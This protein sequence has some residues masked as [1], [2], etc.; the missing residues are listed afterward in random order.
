MHVLDAIPL[1]IKLLICPKVHSEHTKC[2]FS[3]V[4]LLQRIRDLLEYSYN[5]DYNKLAVIYNGINFNRFNTIDSNSVS[6]ATLFVGEVFWQLDDSR[7]PEDVEDR[8]LVDGVEQTN[9]ANHARIV[10][11]KRQLYR[12]CIR[13]FFDC[14]FNILQSEATKRK[15]ERTE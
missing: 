6:G 11:R 13:E 7:I 12:E 5:I 1:A 10:R 9:D 2:L 14:G 8:Q 4:I 3:G 15:T